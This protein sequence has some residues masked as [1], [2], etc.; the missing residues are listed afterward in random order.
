VPLEIVTPEQF[1]SGIWYTID[2]GVHTAIQMW[3]NG[4][5]TRF[6]CFDISKHKSLEVKIVSVNDDILSFMSMHYGSV[7]IEGVALRTGSE[8]S[9]ASGA[10][11]NLFL[12]AYIIGGIIG[13]MSN[14]CDVYDPILYQEWAGQLSYNQL[15][16]ILL[17]KFDC[18]CSNEHIAAARGI[19]FAAKGLL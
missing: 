17:K 10:R 5:M 18:P 11:G 7:L 12:L 9:M 15:R 2:P 16:N 8:V 13:A 3:E 19:G 1:N 6:D 14:Y 4:A